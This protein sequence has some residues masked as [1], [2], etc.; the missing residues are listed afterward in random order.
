[1]FFIFVLD[2]LLFYNFQDV[3]FTYY[4]GYNPRL[5]Y[6]LVKKKKIY[7]HKRILHMT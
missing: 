5:F 1:M 2:D 4:F 3:R 6:I 7:I